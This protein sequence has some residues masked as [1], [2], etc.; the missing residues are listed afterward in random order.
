MHEL[1]TKIAIATRIK[2]LLVVVDSQRRADGS[3]QGL[4]KP[5]NQRAKGLADRVRDGC[6]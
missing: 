2:K 5:T 6:R 1:V 4:P 3:H